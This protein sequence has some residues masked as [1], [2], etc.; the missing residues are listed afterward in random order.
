M[1]WTEL[2]GNGKDGA[3][4]SSW[5]KFGLFVEDTVVFEDIDKEAVVDCAVFEDK[6]SFGTDVNGDESIWAL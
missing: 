6:F 1:G 4:L 5:V 3:V 2:L